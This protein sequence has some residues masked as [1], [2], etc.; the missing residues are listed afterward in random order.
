MVNINGKYR[1]CL[2]AIETSERIFNI[3]ARLLL[4]DLLADL[5]RICEY[6]G[7]V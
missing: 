2:A 4:K 3:S 1:S 5:E 7:R 6:L